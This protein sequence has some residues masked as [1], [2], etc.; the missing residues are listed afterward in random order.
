M[1]RLSPHSTAILFPL[2]DKPRVFPNEVESRPPPARRL[3]RDFFASPTLQVA[4]ALIGKFIVR[5]DESG[6]RAAMITEVEAYKAPRDAAS[7]AYGGRR[8]A[9]VEPLYG[10]PGTL[11]VYL[12]YGLHWMLN[13]ATVARD[14]PEG[15]LVR[16][17]VGDV[18]SQPRIV[19]G[20]GKVAKQLRIERGL[21]GVDATVSEA[22]WFEDRGVRVPRSRIRTGPRVGI[23]YAGEYWAARPWRFRIEVGIEDGKIV[24]RP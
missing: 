10:E 5:R 22:L 13:I 17:V 3:D 14:V 2:A 23:D 9:R 11:Y 7:H 1:P 21:D 8:T 12:I 18:D 15:V 24:L 4:R 16:A 19:D 6:V 20:P